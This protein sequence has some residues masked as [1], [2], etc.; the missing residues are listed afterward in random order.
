[1]FSFTR[2]HL[3][4]HPLYTSNILPTL[5][6][7]GTL[8]DL[9]SGFSAD[10]R[11][12]VSAGVDSRQ[13]T[14]LDN[15]DGFW[16]LGKELFCDEE[17]MKARF[18]VADMKDQSSIPEDMVSSFDMIWAGASFHL[19]DWDGQFKASIV[20]AKMLRAKKGSAIYGY[21]LGRTTGR[22]M[23]TG[24]MFVHDTKTFER[25]WEDVGR[26]VGIRF[27]V[28]TW[29]YDSYVDDLKKGDEEIRRLK[30]A[31]I[32]GDEIVKG[33]VEDAL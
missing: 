1:M 2:L 14:A 22:E 24:G 13:F 25:L 15:H 21:Q 20:A 18:V 27:E 12:L 33:D 4:N 11:A 17:T 26:E 3:I 29:M 30:F 7:G 16:K 19:F 8:L 5:Q 28:K 6:S 31:V 10:F 32:R 9:G 23:K